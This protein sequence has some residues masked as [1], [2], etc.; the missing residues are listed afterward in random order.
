EKGRYVMGD[1][2]EGPNRPSTFAILAASIVGGGSLHYTAQTRHPHSA[3]YVAWQRETG[4]D[5]TEANLKSAADEVIRAFNIHPRRDELLPK[6]DLDF[7]EAGKKLG[8]E[9][10]PTT[11][12]KRNCLYS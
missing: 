4:V 9:V 11:V 6:F 5:W 1:Y 7:R 3:D 8:F 10:S 2:P 12:S